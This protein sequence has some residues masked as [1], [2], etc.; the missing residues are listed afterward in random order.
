MNKLNGITELEL[1]DAAWHGFM[2]KLIQFQAY[3]HSLK[4]QAVKS[5]IAQLQAKISAIE[6][7]MLELRE[8]SK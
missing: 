6:V 7:R 1:L 5:E 3:F 4:S 2:E 8:E